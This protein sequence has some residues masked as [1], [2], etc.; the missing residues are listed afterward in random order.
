MGQ[1]GL[2]RLNNSCVR[3]VCKE[4]SEKVIKKLDMLKELI[5]MMLINGPSEELINK[6]LN[7]IK[8]V[9]IYYKCLGNMKDM[10]K[11]LKERCQQDFADI[12]IISKC[13]LRQE[14]VSKTKGFWLSLVSINYKNDEE[15]K[16]KINEFF[17]D[18]IEKELSNELVAII[19][20]ASEI[21]DTEDE[22]VDVIMDKVNFLLDVMKRKSVRNVY[23][24][25][26]TYLF[27]ANPRLFFPYSGYF[28]QISKKK[29]EFLERI[30]G[31]NLDQV[32]VTK[33]KKFNSNLY[34]NMLKGLYSFMRRHHIN[35]MA[36]LMC[37]I[38]AEETP[39]EIEPHE[40]AIDVMQ[41][42]QGAT[43]SA[44][45]E[46]NLCVEAVKSCQSQHF[47]TILRTLSDMLSSKGQVILYGPPGTGKT[48]L[49][50][51]FVECGINDGRS[52]SAYEFVTFHQS[53]SYE[54]F[55]EGIWPESSGDASPIRYVIRDGIFKRLAILAICDILS[56]MNKE[57]FD[58]VGCGNA[59]ARE[60]SYR[61]DLMRQNNEAHYGRCK[62]KVLLLLKCLE[63]IKKKRN[64][65]GL[66]TILR[67]IHEALS[68]SSN[69]YLVIDEINR[70]DISRILGELITLLEK[71][72]RLGSDPV[73]YPL[74]VRLPYS[75]ELFAVPA[76]LY[77]IGTMN[78]TDRS[79]AL[80][81]IALRRRFAFLEISPDPAI[82]EREVKTQDHELA[83]KLVAFFKEL[84][85]QIE[86]RLDRDHR[87]GH[88]YFLGV[89]SP[90]DLGRV[91]IHEI[92]P[93]LTEYFY[94]RWE[95]LK[96]ALSQILGSLAD[97]FF[98]KI[99]EGYQLR[100]WHEWYEV[101][102]SMEELY[103]VVG[104]DIIRNL[105]TVAEDPEP[106]S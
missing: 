51:R 76:N 88:S 80:V 64:D 95:D 30:S 39:E 77:I 67:A 55:V 87:I 93:L 32:C 98:I 11:E 4:V 28:K 94:N 34:K 20:E 50:K 54:E 22:N 36:E 33:K 17:T 16:E 7:I 1:F 82:I 40:P 81:D 52:G 90:E 44:R 12:N 61:E 31:V 70:G 102:D 92:M 69:Y 24:T 66:C 104:E 53:Y 10:N 79:I 74:I 105:K 59:L 89:R 41:K 15:F 75:Q 27:I 9:E 35:N 101:K 86:E 78:T 84:N 83:Q 26:T 72:K 63:D 97:R 100:D 58:K 91:W 57:V 46:N 23:C 37:L 48:W 25:I 73:S 47:K 103:R 42:V 65:E 3:D 19:K 2:S 96:E 68:R 6:K 99:G 43:T 106:N 71:D 60:S 38:L 14:T 8:E 5:L 49:A 21:R 62:E 18:L 85:R 45:D 29:M 56:H 13:G